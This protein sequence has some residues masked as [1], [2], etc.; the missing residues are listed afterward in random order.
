M[1]LWVIF[2]TGLTVGGVTC[3]AVQGGLLASA[4][5]AREKENIGA[6]LKNKHSIWPIM[7]FLVTKLAAYVILVLF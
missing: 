2:F 4:I 3:M 5:A 6:N 1:D 7:A